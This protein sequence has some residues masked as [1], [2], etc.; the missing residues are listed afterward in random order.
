MLEHGLLQ[1]LIYLGAAALFVP[2]FTRIGLGSVL[3]YL[4]AGIIAGPWG[5]HLIAQD[6]TIEQV[7]ELG[8]VLLMF[9]VGLDLNPARLWQ[10]RRAIFGLGT[11]QVT[12]TTLATALLLM[13]LG[14]SR[15]AAVALGMAAAM[16]STAIAL[17]L[18]TERKRMVSPS[19]QSAFSV[20]LFQDIAVIPL[21]LSMSL[22]AP[23]DGAQATSAP[24]HLS[25]QPI[26]TALAL[27]AGMIVAGRLL[28]RPLMRWVAT[29]G[30]REIFL[31]FALLLVVGSALLTAS[32]GL[33]MAMGAFIAGLLLAD[34]E[35]RLELETDFDPL[36]GLF[37]GLFFMTVGIALDIGA[38]IERPLLLTGLALTIVAVKIVVMIVLGL[39]FGLRR[40]NVI[41]FALSL[42]Q[43]GEF[44]FVLLSAGLEADVIDHA[45]A[46]MAR[47]VVA[48]SMLTTPLLFIAFDR[49]VAPRFRSAARRAP[50]QIDEHN[51]VI[52]A[53]IGRFGQVAVRLLLARNVPV[54]VIDNDPVQ[55]ASVSRFGWKTYYGDA[56]RHD[57][58]HQAGV[59]EA[60]LVLLA[61]DDAPKLVST[62][63][64]LRTHYPKLKI[65]AR[66]RGRP[67]AI[68]LER[69]GVTPIRETFGSALE[70]AERALVIL[71]DEEVRA[72]RLAEQFRA[73]DDALTD[74]LREA[75][76]SDEA[77]AIFDSGR[78]QF[79]RLLET[80]AES[81][82]ETNPDARH[83]QRLEQRREARRQARE[84]RQPPPQSPPPPPPPPP[85]D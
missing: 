49:F 33:S 37:L 38:L 39:L 5:L 3:G 24:P 36:K 67:E 9:L 41:V 63:R 42:S 21:L 80:E 78:T 60:R 64:Y 51:A 82:A 18:L 76:S 70:A 15:P 40:D 83:D 65:L 85:P 14:L 25:W 71:G 44:A 61:F 20:S 45:Q 16:S 59:A 84:Q 11:L 46:A 19:G 12:L 30:M 32:I 48:L 31:S 52:V 17:Q 7:S 53:G 57:V 34:S 10:M 8:V 73:H 75:H 47:T 62:A 13:R 50:D 26:A 81:H 74:R 55:V 28:L 27:I 23:Q 6:E 4:A 29:I 22:L 2:I 54:T 72:A 58:L 69:I 1:A 66:A 68:E 56:S 35:F 43:V 79:V 77:Q